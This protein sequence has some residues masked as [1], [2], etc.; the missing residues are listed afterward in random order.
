MPWPQLV[1]AGALVRRGQL[2]LIVGGPG[3]GKSLFAQSL[4]HRGDDNGLLAETLYFSADTDAGTFAQRAGSISTGY[5]LSD[6]QRLIAE[7][8]DAGLEAAI[9]AHTGHM[10]MC[11][12]SSIGEQELLDELDAYAEIFGRYPTAVCVDNLSNLEMGDA[13]GE[14][15]GLQAACT[16]LHDVARESNAAVIALHHTNSNYE[17]AGQP[18]PLSGIR[19]RVSKTPELIISLHRS[20]DFLKASVI[21]NRSGRAFADGSNAIRIPVDLSRMRLG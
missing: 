9:A 18:I 5:L 2:T 7:G 1:Q 10:R 8:D 4:L 20:G 14:F 3:T 19:G 16:L 17:D 21:K 13:E 12:S 15:Q 11:Y 6:V